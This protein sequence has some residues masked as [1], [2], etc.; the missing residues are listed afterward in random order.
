MVLI[1]QVRAGLLNP[2]V[3]VKFN[4]YTG[5]KGPRWI[6]GIGLVFHD[7]DTKRGWVVSVTPRPPLPPGKA[8]YPLYR[9]L[10]RPESRSERVR[11]TSPPHRDSIP[12][13]S[14]P[15][16]VAIPTTLSR[17]PLNPQEG[18]IIHKESPVG[19]TA[20]DIYRRGERGTE[21]RILA[22]IFS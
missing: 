5:R 8:R 9:R 15:W 1:R 20:L 7:H 18:H 11:K 14:S 22:T 6:R 12:G 13:P 2:Q 10:D 4:P 3:R 21:S 19:R 16:R 17:P